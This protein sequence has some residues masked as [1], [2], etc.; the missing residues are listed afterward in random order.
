MLSNKVI[1]F[2]GLSIL[3]LFV[4]SSASLVMGQKKLEPEEGHPRASYSGYSDR[5][6][7]LQ[8]EAVRQIRPQMHRGGW[9]WDR[10]LERYIDSE[11]RDSN[12]IRIIKGY[13]LSILDRYQEAKENGKKESFTLFYNH[14][15]WG[16]GGRMRIYDELVRQNLLT[17]SEEKEFKELVLHSLKLDF[18]DYSLLERG[19]NNRPYG[20]N[21]GPAIAVKMFPEYP[22]S[23]RHSKWLE[24]LW[25]ELVEYGDTTETNY[26]PY[27]PLYLHGLIDMAYGMNKFNTDRAFLRAHF[28]RYLYYI[29][30]GGVRGNPNSSAN[31]I[32]DQRDEIYADP[33]NAEYYGGA[34]NVNDGHVWYRIAKEFEDPEFLW[35]SEQVCL[36]GRPPEGYQIP[37]EYLEAY[38]KRYFWFIKKG[39]EPSVPKGGSSIGYYSPLKYKIPER[40]YLC[41]SRESGKPFVSFFIYDRNNNYMHYCDDSDGKLYEYC[42]DGAKFLH[43]SGKYTSGRAGVGET[44]Y[45]MLSV[46]PPDMI[47]PIKSGGGMD[48]PTGEAWKMSSMSIKLALNSREGPDSKNWIFDDKIKHFRRTDQRELGFSYGNMDGYWQLNNQYQLESLRI[49]PF[50]SGSKIQNLRISGPAGEKILESFNSLSDKMEIEIVNGENRIPLNNS[51][52]DLL[53]KVVDGGRRSGKCIEIGDIGEGN[54]IAF[55]FKNLNQNFDAQNEFTRISYDFQGRSNGGITPNVRTN[56]RYFTPLWHRGAILEK[57]DLRA[58]NKNEDSFGQFSMRNYYGSNSRWTRQCVLTE[59]GYLIVRDRYVPCSDV[60]GYIAGPCWSIA[61]SN[62]IPENGSQWFDAPARDHAWW[63]KK[64]KRVILYIHRHEGHEIGQVET[65]TSQ[66]IGG[67]RVRNTFSKATIIAGKPVVWLSVFRPYDQ[68]QNKA[69]VASGIKTMVDQNDNISARIDDTIVSI[70]QNGEWSVKRN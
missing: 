47:F 48:T 5:E 60:D 12:E 24:A 8:I 13:F 46:L 39:I 10:L 50:S 1:K 69:Q 61:S 9:E 2:L 3:L 36:G 20:I 70:T 53:C 17:K 25:R 16:S 30:G 38:Q 56:P 33:W 35:A 19:V 21:A 57:N 42:V 63:Q 68:G 59:E 18:P 55:T 14:K 41:S 44:A 45:D 37:N 34:E 43:T 65:R 54:G 11:R 6:I 4:I 15:S 27:G 58:E 7:K 49:G 52:R 62:E 31:I 64:K 28:R 40:L 29:H 32:Q 66:D 23:A 51:M 22:V 67:A 26:Y